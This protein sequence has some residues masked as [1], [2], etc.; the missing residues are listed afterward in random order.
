M[1]AFRD[2]L[3]NIEAPADLAHVEV[4]GLSADSR[5]VQPGF[6]FFAVPGAKADGLSFAPAAVAAGAV[7]VVAEHAP[8]TPLGAPCFVVE[9]V[10]AALSRAAARLYP[11]QPATIVAITGTSG[12]TSTA[13]FA[14]QIWARLGHQAAALGTTG[15]VK[16]SGATYGSLTTPDPVTLHKTLDELAG[17]GVTHLAMEASS[18]GL[19]QRRLDGVRLS[20]AG[21]TNLSRD[22][23]DYH[24]S[25][26]DYL[27]AKMRLFDTLTPVGQPAVID[28][29]SEIADDVIGYCRQCG[30]EVFTTG[31]KGA[32]IKLI[33][34]AAE[35]GATRVVV[36]H[37][38]ARI[39]L[40]LPL[41]GDFMV[42]NALVAAGLCVATGSKIEDALAALEHLEGAPGRL[43]KVGE[44]D[45][46]PV[47]VDYAHKPDALEKML[48]ALRAAATKRLIVVF[49]CGGD[50]DRG[51]RA[52]MGEI[53]TR[54]ADVVF[55]TD[56]NPR[57]EDPASIRAEIL[58]AAP[59]AREIPGRAEAID[60]AVEI[61]RAG[62]VLVI[63]GKGHETGQIVGGTVLPFSD[64]EAARAALA[65]H[66]R[67]ATPRS[68]KAAPLWT[69]LGL[70]TPLNARVAGRVPPGCDGVS[71]DTRTLV[72]GDLFVA[73][74]GDNNDGHD[75]VARAFEKG[76]AAALVD[77]AHAAALKA[78][79]PLYIV[80]D[81]LRA[82]ENLGR[83]AR[84][85]SGARVI[86]VTGSVGKTGVKEALKLVLSR[87]GAT[88]ASAASYNNHWGVPLTLAR[89]PAATRFGVF[90]IG[91]NHAGEITPL[92]GM[93]RPHVAVVTTIA[94]V[95]L[96]YFGSLDAIAEA[97]A[98]IFS[99]LEPGGT[100]IVNRDIAQYDLLLSRAKASPAVD[101]LSFGE[102]EGADARLLDYSPAPEGS[103]VRATFRGRELTYRVAA[104]GKHMAA[105]SLAVLLTASAAGADIEAMARAL[106][107][108]EAP[109]GRGQ[110]S[111]L[112]A[113]AGL[114]TLIDESY[115]ANPASM[116]A[117]L[118]ILGA[119]DIP[120]RGRRIA[121]LGDML[122]L[123]AESARLHVELAEAIAAN[124]IDIVFAAGPAMRALRDALPAETRG[125]WAD[126]SADIED[127]VLDYIAAGDVV[128]VKGSNGSRM[129]PLVAAI[130]SRFAAEQGAEG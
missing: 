28:A 128:M 64:H 61:L 78:V 4:V 70:V 46:A 116:R 123:G 52:M 5:A 77:E 33:D 93:V 68:A 73:L 24:A 44:R 3:P 71:I 39:N 85:R 16:P 69:G 125:A 76:A 14:R 102:H 31:A 122:E 96:E 101:V 2:L 66:T 15:V 41:A 58:A 9:D 104:A 13:A 86:A 42:S 45:G 124:R 72:A 23:L 82:L 7:A 118:A 97:K 22:H 63:A 59:G 100:A 11:R 115:N 117:A 62:D 74:K 119:A 20:A 129:G 127:R 92:V 60:A 106:G 1:T 81:T 8:E 88:H 80:H 94:P 38:G 99:G 36:E 89:M 57:S 98:E 108:F 113:G 56:D 87:A 30:L 95:H 67:V 19:D 37:A 6:V 32:D 27:A 54:E 112:P 114:F 120:A 110:Q 109:T 53:A 105:N 10:R 25:L 17:E 18:H 90:E 107:E 26:D 50:R 47:Y 40:R 75:H 130:K 49:G 126:K 91:M 55:V 35:A 84:A 43:E 65:K 21:F 51:K 121:V 103:L 79:E 12:K 34:A 83:A 111:R 29:D 48:R